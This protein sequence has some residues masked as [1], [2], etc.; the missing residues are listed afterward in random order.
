MVTVPPAA[1]IFSRAEAEKACAPRPTERGADRGAEK[2]ERAHRPHRPAAGPPKPK[3]ELPPYLR[4]V[5]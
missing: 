3:R 5:K 4:V 2:A 1:V